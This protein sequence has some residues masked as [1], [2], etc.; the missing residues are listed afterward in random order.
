MQ[1]TYDIEVSDIIIIIVIIIII[2]I[3]LIIIIITRFSLL[4]VFDTEGGGRNTKLLIPRPHTPIMTPETIIFLIIATV[5]PMRS[6]ME[7]QYSR[8]MYMHL[9]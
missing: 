4:A 3:I 7:A 2:I 6:T 9:Y 8:C 5:L 1:V